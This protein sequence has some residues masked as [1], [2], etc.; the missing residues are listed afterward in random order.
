MCD[1]HDGGARR[2]VDVVQ[3]LVDVEGWAGGPAGEAGRGGETIDLQ[4]QLHAIGGREEALELDDAELAHR[5][6]LDLGDEAAEIEVATRRPGGLEQVRQED[7]LA[8][9]DRVALDT[10]QAEQARCEA[11]DLVLDALGV[12]LGTRRVHRADDVQGDTG[13]ASRRVDRD[14]GRGLEPTHALAVDLPRLETLLPHRCGGG[15]FLADTDSLAL[16]EYRIDPRFEGARREVGKGERE[17]AHVAFGV[18]HEN[19]NALQ[20]CFLQQDHA[21]SGLAG[22]GHAHDHAVGG[23]RRRLVED[24]VAG[25]I[26]TGGVDDATEIQLTCWNVHTLSFVPA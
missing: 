25:P 13:R 19:G 8:P 7:V 26:V 21:Q 14:V 2:T 9:T 12:E 10:D 18:D 17:V 24:G 15:R 3:Q 4:G 16:G 23:E 11:V 5:G 1:R 20:Q 22:T 6:F